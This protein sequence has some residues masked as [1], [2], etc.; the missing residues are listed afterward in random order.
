MNSYETI[1]DAYWEEIRV[2][3]MLKRSR[4]RKAKCQKRKFPPNV[5]ELLTANIKTVTEMQ[6]QK[7]KNSTCEE[8]HTYTL[9]NRD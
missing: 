5:V 9:R 2:E 4:L 8:D 1:H 3:R 6:E 7:Q